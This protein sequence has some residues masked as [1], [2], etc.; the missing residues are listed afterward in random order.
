VLTVGYVSSYARMF[1]D[2]SKCMQCI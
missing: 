2:V 1:V